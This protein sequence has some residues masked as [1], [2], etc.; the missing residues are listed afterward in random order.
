MSNP[1]NWQNV[2]GPT[3]ADLQTVAPIEN[4]PTTTVVTTGVFALMFRAELC[5]WPTVG[6]TVI[7]DG[8]AE[9]RAFRGDLTEASV[10]ELP[11]DK[12]I[13]ASMHKLTVQPVPLGNTR[14]LLATVQLGD[15]E[16][17][18][19]AA[20]RWRR[21]LA[22]DY[23]EGRL[24]EDMLLENEPLEVEP[25]VDLTYPEVEELLVTMPHLD[26]SFVTHRQLKIISARWQKLG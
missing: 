5:D 13:V 7:V 4:R 24:D 1:V 22:R 3:G 11:L 15:N 12:P 20:P 25:N 18:L 14:R 9:V 6:N 10:V 16:A 19:Q 2:Y 21:N 26:D 8:L 23:R 17:Y